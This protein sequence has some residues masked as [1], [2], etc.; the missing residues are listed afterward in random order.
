MRGIEP[1]TLG[2]SDNAR[3]FDGDRLGIFLKTV[4]LSSFWP[5]NLTISD[6]ASY[7][8]PKSDCQRIVNL[9]CKQ[10][11]LDNLTKDFLADDQANTLVGF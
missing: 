3:A 4:D 2:E 1:V 5:R 6:S 7:A 9:N 10:D 11:R 8:S